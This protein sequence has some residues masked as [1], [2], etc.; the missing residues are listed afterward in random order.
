MK[1]TYFCAFQR[2]LLYKGAIYFLR[3]E[4]K[5]TILPT[6]MTSSQPKLTPSMRRIL[7]DWMI[8]ASSTSFKYEIQDEP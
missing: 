5:I 4:M 7:V 8:Q 6:Y 1:K 3:E 2:H